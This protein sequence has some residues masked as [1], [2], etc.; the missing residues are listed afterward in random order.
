M[1]KK[2]IAVISGINANIH[3]LS[4]FLTFIED[5][6]LNIDY[7]LNLGNFIQ[8]GPNP[9]EVFDVVMND[10][11]FINVLG[12]DEYSL[13]Y[14]NTEQ[15]K[16][17]DEL[18]INLNEIW[19][20]EQLG[21]YRLQQLG[22][23][24]KYKEMNIYDNKILLLH[25][26]HF[27]GF[28]WEHKLLV[29]IGNNRCLASFE[30]K[31][32]F[33]YDYIFCG[34]RATQELNVFTHPSVLPNKSLTIVNPGDLCCFINNI[35]NFVIVEFENEKSDILFKRIQYDLDVALKEICTKDI[36]DK[37]TILKE[38]YK[39]NDINSILNKSVF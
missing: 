24:S 26:T 37:D 5:N 16:C 15:D 31:Q 38:Y 21:N 10:K 19:T 25:T 27:I 28:D 1:S 30:Y 8:N 17:K 36:P 3:S 9:N 4:A 29:S 22:H 23:L 39:I 7:I 33:N 34:N 14:K 6:K 35:I 12:P 2:R 32:I 13:L 20:K 18:N 11:R